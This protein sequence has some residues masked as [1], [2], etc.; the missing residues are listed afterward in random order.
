[1][2]FDKLAS[3]L[4]KGDSLT[5]EELENIT[6]H[7]R[8]TDGYGLAVLDLRDGLMK[9]FTDR[10]RPATVAIIKGKMKVLTDPEATTYNRKA[11]G[12]GLRKA[13][14]AHSR[15]GEVDTRALSGEQKQQHERAMLV[16]GKL[17]AVIRSTR[18]K[19]AADN[20]QRQG[21]NGHLRTTPGLP[22]IQPS[23]T[24]E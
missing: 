20:R 4:H 21:S 5:C 19:L 14:R 13:N 10:G 9:A 22:L 23:I 17:L 24:D 2:D 18:A 11:F 12:N 1:M 3:R 8:R 16:T 15:L 7:R 6:G